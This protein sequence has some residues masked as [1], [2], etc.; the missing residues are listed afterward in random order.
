MYELQFS[1]QSLK[2]IKELESKRKNQIKKALDLLKKDPF[3]QPYKKLNGTQA[4]FRIRIGNF[5]EN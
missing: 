4:D 5:F 3:S 1:K 2:F